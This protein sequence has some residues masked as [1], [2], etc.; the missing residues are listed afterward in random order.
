MIRDESFNYSKLT[1]SQ[2]S[3]INTLAR[4]DDFTC[5]HCVRPAMVVTRMSLPAIYQR[6]S[7]RLSYKRKRNWRSCG[8]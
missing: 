4:Q 3:V 8:G 2:F 1:C 5:P 7:I 6:Q